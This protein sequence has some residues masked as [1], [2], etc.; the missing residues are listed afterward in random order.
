MK[1]ITKEL[2]GQSENLVERKIAANIITV[3]GSNVILDSDLA[4]LYG[5]ETRR[6]NE[7]VR[8]NISRFPED[9]MFQLTEE[10]YGILMSQNATT[11]SNWGGRRKLPLVFTE[12][13]ALQ[14]ANV[15][16]SEQANR[17]SVFI[18]RVFVKLRQLLLSNEVLSRKLEKLEERVNQHDTI[19][20]SIVEEIRNLI[21]PPEPKQS[22][23]IGFRMPKATEKE[24]G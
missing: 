21:E 23:P 19:L 9:F 3:R 16:N 13:G 24:E 20:V 1:G 4:R 7:Q 17:V 5:V 11:R 14:A 22:D 6:L 2:S 10:E 15:L 8:R 18:I 12:H